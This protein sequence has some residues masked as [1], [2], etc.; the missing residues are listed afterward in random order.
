M[1]S[2]ALITRDTIEEKIRLL[3]QQKQ[4]LADSL[5]TGDA[6]I[7]KRLTEEDIKYI[8]GN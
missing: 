1:L 6:A 5:I 7:T 4:D 8:F 2:F 3:Q